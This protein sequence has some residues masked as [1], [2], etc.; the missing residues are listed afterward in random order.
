MIQNRQQNL[1]QINPLH[2]LKPYIKYISTLP[3]YKGLELPSRRFPQ[4]M[5]MHFSYPTYML[6]APPISPP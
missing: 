3:S 2:T 6:Y 1:S 5:C 4:K